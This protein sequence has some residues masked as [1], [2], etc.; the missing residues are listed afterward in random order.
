MY[1]NV[2]E[3]GAVIL[4]TVPELMSPLTGCCRGDQR[5]G[6]TVCRA[7]DLPDQHLRRRRMHVDRRDRHHVSGAGDQVFYANGMSASSPVVSYRY[8]ASSDLS[9]SS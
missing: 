4:G 9:D 8:S 6:E 3:L 2:Q 1:Q 7:A 5:N